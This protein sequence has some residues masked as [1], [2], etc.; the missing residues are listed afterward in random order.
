MFF[1]FKD[2]L[3]NVLLENACFLDKYRKRENKGYSYLWNW[4]R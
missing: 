3:E 1:N 2:G 4:D